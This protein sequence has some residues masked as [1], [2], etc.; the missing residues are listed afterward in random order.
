MLREGA[1]F[2]TL[3]TTTDK[4]TNNAD[5]LTLAMRLDSLKV[6]NDLT[7]AL[8]EVRHEPTTAA[9]LL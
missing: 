3:L 7:K 4:E 9:V 1:T 2:L 6:I 8:M 5:K